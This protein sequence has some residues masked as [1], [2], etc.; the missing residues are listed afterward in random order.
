MRLS[1]ALIK[2]NSSKLISVSQW[3]REHTKRCETINGESFFSFFFFASFLLHVELQ[4][5][6]ATLLIGLLLFAWGLVTVVVPIYDFV[7]IE[8]L[9]MQPGL[10]PYE[11]WVIPTPE[12]RL[13]VYIFSVANP[14]SFLN[15]TDKKLRLI[16]IGP[17]VYREHLHHQNVTFHENST[18]SYTA[19]RT[20]EFLE[21]QNEPGILERV[22]QVPNFV[23][24][25][26]KH[27]LN[28]KSSKST[29]ISSQSMLHAFYC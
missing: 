4:G 10:P 3:K 1:V 21:D 7:R 5:T 9:K 23:L 11:Q 6:I 14:D 18:L 19:H 25:V 29:H 2:R 22:I 8:R 24:L 15:G 13:S 20:L 27:K 16:E 17:I 12:V 26:I 28:A